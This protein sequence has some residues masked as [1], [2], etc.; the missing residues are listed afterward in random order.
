MFVE[1]SLHSIRKHFIKI[2]W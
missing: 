2:K 1:T